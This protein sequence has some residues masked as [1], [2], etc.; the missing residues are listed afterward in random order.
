MVTGVKGE[1]KELRRLHRKNSLFGSVLYYYILPRFPLF[2]NQ[3]Y[4]PVFLRVFH[5][6]FWI[7]EL[8]KSF[9][10]GLFLIILHKLTICPKIVN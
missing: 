7:G 10:V 1:K 8:I 6:S 4:P 2:S 3:A 9:E 5:K